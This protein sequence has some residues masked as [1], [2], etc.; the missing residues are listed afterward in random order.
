MI[1]AEE[2][3]GGGCSGCHAN[4]LENKREISFKKNDLLIDY[5]MI[6]G[7]YNYFW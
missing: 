5:E 7:L 1:G 2:W 6:Q 4:G 3:V